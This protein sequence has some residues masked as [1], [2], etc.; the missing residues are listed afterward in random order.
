M[1]AP[2]VTAE[3]VAYAMARMHAYGRRSGTVGEI[4]DRN[5]MN[6]AANIVPHGQDAGLPDARHKSRI[7]GLLNTH[8]F[9]GQPTHFYSLKFATMR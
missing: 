4:A 3:S 9:Y 6:N 7:R 1:N 8:N 5:T 2:K